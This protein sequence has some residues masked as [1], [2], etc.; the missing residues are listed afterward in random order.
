[1]S[2]NRIVPLSLFVISLF[3][4]TVAEAQ[5]VTTLTIGDTAPPIHVSKWL[6]GKPVKQFERG[7]IYVVEFWATWCLPCIGNMPHLSELAGKYRDKITVTGVD[8]MERKNLP[9]GRSERFVDSMG[10]HMDYNVAVDDSDFMAGRWLAA[11]G[12][13]AIPAA[14]VVD[15][16]GVI[17]WI[18]LPRYL[19]TVLP[20]VINHTW[21]NKAA[22]EARQE[23]Q[24]LTKL[25]NEVITIMNPYMGKT[26]NPEG[27]LLTIDSIL[28][29][30]PA[31]RFYPYTAHF[32]FYAIIKTDPVKAVA[33]GRE[34]L[35]AR[36]EPKWNSITEAVEYRMEIAKDTLPAGMYELAADCYVAQIQNYPWSMN[37]PATYDKAAR[38]WSLAGDKEK[39]I[40][41][42]KHAIEAGT[43]KAGFSEKELAD[44]QL[45]LTKYGS[46]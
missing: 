2:V 10:K 19:D 44:Y 17:A 16:A 20:A 23:N 33:F 34:W 27:A 25:D 6:K 45:R 32:T 29:R 4:A 43:Q 9:P 18:G 1:M 38:L 42:E 24:R 31:L 3:T 46:R 11:S 12:S 26:G 7:K 36:K 14:Y 41:A 28:A 21:N 8:V 15:E 40:A 39:A 37:I 13:R 5:A 30:E 35:Q 22:L